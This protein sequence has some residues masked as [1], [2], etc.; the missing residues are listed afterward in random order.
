MPPARDSLAVSSSPGQIPAGATV[1]GRFRID[2]VLQQD[3]VSQTYRAID[4]G[5]HGAAAVRVIPMRV[6]GAAAAQL[7][8]DIEKASALVHKNLVEVLNVGREADFFYIATELLDG[9]TLREFVD[10]RRREGR[11]VSFKG[12]CNLI[13]HI[14]NGLER[15]A[16]LPAPRRAQPGDRLG[17]QGGA[18]EGRRARAAAHAAVAGAAGRPR[19]RARTRPTSR[20]RCSAGQPATLASDVYSLGVILYEVLTGTAA[21]GAAAAREP[22]RRRTRRPRS[23]G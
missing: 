18:G 22:G 15:A 19:R 3:A 4:L 23:T 17:Q 1:G 9:Q 11:N 2:G 14:A 16:E 10:G 7:E 8:A 12:A 20:P 6:L 21:V 5:N 13:T